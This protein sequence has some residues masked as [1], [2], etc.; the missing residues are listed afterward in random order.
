MASEK[1]FPQQFNEF[2]ERNKDSL[3]QEP[4]DGPQIVNPP[5]N[6]LPPSDF[7]QADLPKVVEV[8]RDGVRD[9]IES[10]STFSIVEASRE[11]RKLPSISED[12]LSKKSKDLLRNTKLASNLLKSE[13]PNDVGETLAGAGADYVIDKAG[14]GIAKGVGKV[15]GGGAAKVA[16]TAFGAFTMALTNHEKIVD[17]EVERQRLR[18][19]QKQK[20]KPGE[21]ERQHLRD[22]GV[23]DKEEYLP[24]PYEQ[25]S[26]EALKRINGLLDQ[27]IDVEM[28]TSEALSKINENQITLIYEG[29]IANDQ[30]AN[31]EKYEPKLSESLLQKIKESDSSFKPSEEL[32]AKKEELKQKHQRHADIAFTKPYK[33]KCSHK[34]YRRPEKVNGSDEELKNEWNSILEDL[35]ILEKD[36]KEQEER[37][38]RR[39]VRN[40]AVKSEELKPEIRAFEKRQEDFKVQVF[41]NNKEIQD[42]F[43]ERNDSLKKEEEQKEKESKEKNQA[44]DAGIKHAL[45]D[46]DHA[47]IDCFS[48]ENAN[49]NSND[50]SGDDFLDDIDIYEELQQDNPLSEEGYV[51]SLLEEKSLIENT[52]SKLKLLKDIRNESKKD[53]LFAVD[54]IASLKQDVN[55]YNSVVDSQKG[56]TRRLEREHRDREASTLYEPYEEKKKR[57]D[58]I[59]ESKQKEKD[60]KYEHG[61]RITKLE[62]AEVLKQKK[63]DYLNSNRK[64]TST[65]DIDSLEHKLDRA[66]ENNNS[67]LEQARKDD[68]RLAG[69]ARKIHCSIDGISKATEDLVNE[70]R[71]SQGKGKVSSGARNHADVLKDK[72]VESYNDIQ[73]NQKAEISKRNEMIASDDHVRDLKAKRMLVGKEAMPDEII[74]LEAKYNQEKAKADKLEDSFKKLKKKSEL[75]NGECEYQRL[76]FKGL[77]GWFKDQSNYQKYREETIA[78]QRQVYQTFSDVR[79]QREKEEGLK[80]EL[81]KTKKA[82]YDK[83]EVIKSEITKKINEGEGN[84]ASLRSELHSLYDDSRRLR[85]RLSTNLKEFGSYYEKLDSFA[86]A[87]GLSVASAYSGSESGKKTAEI[88]S[89]AYE[90]LGKILLDETGQALTEK[91]KKALHRVAYDP[92]LLTDEEKQEL[93]E[94]RAKKQEE[95]KLLDQELAKYPT[96]R[97]KQELEE[98]ATRA[99][100]IQEV[101]SAI[102]EHVYK[103][104]SKTESGKKTLRDVESALEKFKTD[105]TGESLTADERRAVDDIKE[106]FNEIADGKEQEPDT[107]LGIMSDIAGEVDWSGAARGGLE[108]VVDKVGPS[109]GYRRLTER[110]QTEATIKVLQSVGVLSEPKERPA[111]EE[112]NVVLESVE[113]GVVVGGAAGIGALLVSGNATITAAGG[114]VIASGAAP[115]ILPF[116]AAGA[117]G[118]LVYGGYRY[119]TEEKDEKK[120]TPEPV[121][122]P[123]SSSSSSSN[124]QPKPPERKFTKKISPQPPSSQKQQI[125]PQRSSSY[126]DHVSKDKDNKRGNGKK[127]SYVSKVSGS[128][129]LGKS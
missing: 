94:E 127:P 76:K 73:K 22:A 61:L 72:V 1:P 29:Q 20:L 38:I 11:S 122:K 41:E 56:E 105:R 59:A 128:S 126:V 50:I 25:K 124:S 26:K 96:Y 47:S 111:N 65:N 97:E 125:K 71:D 55:H 42:D 62:N 9:I 16:G 119:F 63:D 107:V 129:S 28:S 86:T 112:K 57:L 7:S 90:G 51:Q 93:A 37:E 13:S 117:F 69:K 104:Y 21:R 31:I 32:R 100:E 109:L 82:E 64:T 87:V 81:K 67:K 99:V 43:K 91:D 113:G 115:L 84:T 44:I 102:F 54:D 30:L 75:M 24:Q 58:G 36:I 2:V 83:R 103:D 114:L 120:E 39:H 85:G 17:D 101:R 110:E 8:I 121:S 78:T 12:Q 53:P 15:L 18:N 60:L 68:K 3:L 27:K 14:E 77:F 106:R 34:T 45:N 88:M 33:Y 5:K 46:L 92:V 23:A 123:K 74:K 95:V 108:I 49:N 52:K 66:S 80:K 116:A 4:Y 98:A 79:K 19:A 35:P 118:G 70:I 48:A 6:K 89:D 10:E 40:N